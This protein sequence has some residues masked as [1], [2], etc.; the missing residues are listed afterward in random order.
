MRIAGSFRIHVVRSDASDGSHLG[1]RRIV[2]A[3]S[4]S[5]GL[6]PFVVQ[7]MS[8]PRSIV[9]RS[10]YRVH[11]PMCCVHLECDPRELHVCIVGCR[12][13]GLMSLRCTSGHAFACCNAQGVG[14]S[15]HRR[16]GE[17]SAFAS[18]GA[19]A[20][21]VVRCRSVCCAALGWIVAH[22]STA[23]PSDIAFALATH[24]QS[25]VHTEPAVVSQW[26]AFGAAPW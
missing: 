22:A 12:Q 16:L 5:L 6:A 7:R 9:M 18:H 3:V 2:L 23:V 24:S 11:A 26:R 20:C 25:G 4:T 14:G 10:S 17:R 1:R 15:V 8:A 13:M 21:A 19:Y